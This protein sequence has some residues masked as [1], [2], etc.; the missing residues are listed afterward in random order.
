MARLKDLKVSIGLNKKG[1]TK[2]NKDLRDVK[3][4]FRRNF[5]EIAALASNA[6]LA[7]GTTLVAGLTAL[8]RAGAKM[9]TLSVSFRSITGSA[10]G[11]AR[12]VVTLNKFAASTPFQL[13][14]ISSAARQLLAVGCLLYTSPSPR[15]RQKSRMP[16][17]A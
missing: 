6:A 12:M 7:I 13:E 16:S 1:L 5:G 11:A 2:L 17:S 9:E 8:I 10:K 3:G 15:D 14:N 4:N